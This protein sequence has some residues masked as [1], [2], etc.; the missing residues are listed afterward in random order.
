MTDLAPDFFI[1]VIQPEQD[2]A[3]LL[4]NGRSVR[5]S[6]SQLEKLIKDCQRAHKNIEIY[7]GKR[8]AEEVIR[9]EFFTFTRSG[10]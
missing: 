3:L 6:K 8:A 1:P 2:S 7:E 5:L 4:V 10:E 9:L